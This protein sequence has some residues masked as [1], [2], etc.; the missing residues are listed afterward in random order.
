[1][2]RQKPQ[3]KI[4]AEKLQERKSRLRYFTYDHY[5]SNSKWQECK[6]CG[7]EF[8]KE[9]GW[10]VLDRSNPFHPRIFYIDEDCMRSEEDLLDYLEGLGKEYNI[11]P[12]R[13]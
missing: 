6:I 12:K 1:M 4:D 2:K 3:E 10:E 7:L 8:K 9:W 13:D 5:L 11:P